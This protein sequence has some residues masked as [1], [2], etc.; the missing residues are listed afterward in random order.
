[1]AEQPATDING[2][3]DPELPHDFVVSPEILFATSTATSEIPSEELD[4]PLED[5]EKISCSAI[6]NLPV[7]LNIILSTLEVF[8]NDS[9][10][11][12]TEGCVYDVNIVLICS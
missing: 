5:S 8:L 2:L 1:M 12:R 7:H 3:S 9:F 6:P 4:G 11:I 10:Q